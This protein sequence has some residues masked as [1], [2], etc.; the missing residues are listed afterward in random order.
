MP[1]PLILTSASAL[2]STGPFANS[3]SHNVSFLSS[4]SPHASLASNYSSSNTG[5][6]HSSS[7]NV[8]VGNNHT[9]LLPAP[10]FSQPILNDD[11]LDI[12]DEKRKRIPTPIPVLQSQKNTPSLKSSDSTSRTE[13]K[14]QQRLDDAGSTK[15]HHGNGGILNGAASP[16]SVSSHASIGSGS[17]T[18]ANG[19][20]P[21]FST[22]KPEPNRHHLL[23]Y[24]NR[25]SDGYCSDA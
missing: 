20:R 13:K 5:D 18:S 22:F 19:S 14:L 21:N 25:L 24:K 10:L 17:A 11:L 1:P 3:F 9:P 2:T 23:L 15:G 6:G 7:S 12:G 16:M 4:S 8:G